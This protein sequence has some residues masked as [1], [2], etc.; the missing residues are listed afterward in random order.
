MDIVRIC[1]KNPN[2]SIQDGYKKKV[3]LKKHPE[4]IETILSFW[5]QL[6]NVPFELTDAPKGA[7]FEHF[8]TYL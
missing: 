4:N 3:H 5:L 8:C 6:T 1:T 2:K 7:I